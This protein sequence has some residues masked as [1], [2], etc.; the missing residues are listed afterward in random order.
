MLLLVSDSENPSRPEVTILADESTEQVHHH[1]Y[2][3]R[4]YFMVRSIK[5]ESPIVT[6]ASGNNLC[7]INA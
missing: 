4:K 2:L 5:T 6:P 1:N 7:V 3:E